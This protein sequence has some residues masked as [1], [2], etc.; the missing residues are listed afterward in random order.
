MSWVSH[1]EGQD[2]STHIEIVE[3]QDADQLQKSST[4]VSKEK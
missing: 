1:T 2:K 3:K 4:F